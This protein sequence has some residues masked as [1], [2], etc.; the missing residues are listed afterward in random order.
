[1]ASVTQV[2]RALADLLSDLDCRVT[3]AGTDFAT[4]R[5]LDTTK[6]QVRVRVGLD[7]ETTC[8]RLDLLLDPEGDQ[9]IKQRLEADRSLGGLV[10][11]VQVI[12][13]SGY[14]LFPSP[15]GDVL[16]ATFT[17]QIH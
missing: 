7:G 8:E 13:A 3:P 5:G 9:S 10:S 14:Q 11:A 4:D 12:K 15:E 6:Y 16:G 1:M 17:V 2:R